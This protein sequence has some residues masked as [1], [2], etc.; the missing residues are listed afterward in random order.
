MKANFFLVVSPPPT[1]EIDD[2]HLFFCLTQGRGR[3]TGLYTCRRG[4]T[5]QSLKLTSLPQPCALGVTCDASGNKIGGG[6]VDSAFS[7]RQL[8]G[9]EFQADG[10]PQCR[11]ELNPDGCVPLPK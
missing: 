8:T 9:E 11:V 7:R 1:R 3:P 10:P 4:E 6:R 2:H 5:V